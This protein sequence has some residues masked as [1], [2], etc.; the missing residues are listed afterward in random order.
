MATVADDDG[1]GSRHALVLDPDIGGEAT[2]EVRDLVLERDS[3]VCTPSPTA[4]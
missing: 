3:R 1:V 4:R 2:T